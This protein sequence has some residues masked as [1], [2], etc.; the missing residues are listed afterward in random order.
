M[1]TGWWAKLQGRD[2]REEK[3]IRGHDSRGGN[4]TFKKKVKTITQIKWKAEQTTDKREESWWSY[5]KYEELRKLTSFYFD[6]SVFFTQSWGGA[7][8]VVSAKS[9][10]SFLNSQQSILGQSEAAAN[11]ELCLRCCSI[12]QQQ[13]LLCGAFAVLWNRTRPSDF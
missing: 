8:R 9:V 3:R 10:K 13:R 5:K 2:L 11:Q 1:H 4:G 12:L 6:D 7:W